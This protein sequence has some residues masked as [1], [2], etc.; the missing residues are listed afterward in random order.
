MV[1]LV[2]DD[3]ALKHTE[4]KH[5]CNG[6]LSDGR[7]CDAIGSTR[8]MVV[9]A[10]DRAGFTLVVNNVKFFF[11]GICWKIC[12]KCVNCDIAWCW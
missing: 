2:M 7:W 8:V 5:S 4:L 9:M 10:M 11:R 1:V 6:C 3:G 12:F